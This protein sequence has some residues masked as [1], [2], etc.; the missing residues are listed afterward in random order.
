MTSEPSPAADPAIARYY[1][2]SPEED[3]LTLGA[4][5]L[6]AVR[7]VETEPSLVGVSAHLLLVARSA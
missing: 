3:S 2:L 6:E 5:L 4:S 1:A 7:P